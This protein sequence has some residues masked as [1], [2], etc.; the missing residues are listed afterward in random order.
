MP[1]SLKTLNIFSKGTMSAFAVHN[2]A[3]IFAWLVLSKILYYNL[4]PVVP[5]I[6]RLEY[7]IWMEKS[8]V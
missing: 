2:Y 6:K 3:P 4:L 8:L 5:K 1:A 7:A